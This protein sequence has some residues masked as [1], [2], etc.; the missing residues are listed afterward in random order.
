M[1]SIQTDTASMVREGMSAL[2]PC[3]S[4]CTDFH[5]M[6]QCSYLREAHQAMPIGHLGCAYWHTLGSS[7]V[8]TWSHLG[9]LSSV[10]WVQVA[11]VWFTIA[12]INL[13]WRQHR[14]AK[15]LILESNVTSQCH[16][17]HWDLGRHTA[18][19]QYSTEKAEPRQ[20]FHLFL[21]SSTP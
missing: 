1:P 20:S 5:K 13:S 15:T 12:L 4:T 16:G 3:C 14:H 9:N 7:N 11:R 2:S 6:R 21:E 19:A 18:D 8:S 17:S 10:E